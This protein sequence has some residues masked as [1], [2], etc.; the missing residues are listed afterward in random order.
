MAR[1]VTAQAFQVDFST[2]DGLDALAPPFFVKLDAAKQVVDVGDGQRGL[3]V[4][5]G[6]FHHLVDAV[7]PVND[8]KF[9]VKAQ[10]NK[11]ASDCRDT[12]LLRMAG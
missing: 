11:H 10:V 9:G 7:G 8:R 3:L 1:R 12:P 2:E 5:G 6:G 4:G